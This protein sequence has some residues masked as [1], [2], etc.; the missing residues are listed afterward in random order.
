[1]ET[2]ATAL[3]RSTTCKWIHTKF[4]HSPHPFGLVCKTQ[5]VAE[6]RETGPASPA[7]Q[8]AARSFIA[9]SFW[10]NLSQRNG[11]IYVTLTEVTLIF[12]EV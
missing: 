10:L 4:Q 8:I 5:S 9:K 6:L 7:F 3:L 2:D 12:H 1:M 11:T